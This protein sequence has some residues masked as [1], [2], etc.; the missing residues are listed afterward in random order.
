MIP[1]ARPILGPG[2]TVLALS[3]PRHDILLLDMSRPKAL[4]DLG[5]IV[6]LVLA[7]ELVAQLAALG[8]VR[9]AVG[10]DF[11]PSMFDDP[12]FERITSMVLLPFRA[13]GVLVVVLALVR[14]RG[15]TRR[16]IG[17]ST[18]RW[19]LDALI[20]AGATLA[21]FVLIYMWQ[22]LVWLVWPEMIKQMMEN[23]DR[24]IA[25]IPKLHPLS[26][27][28]VACIVG[29]Y[30]EVLFRGFLLPRLRR[31]TNSWPLAIIISTA[32]FTALHAGDQTF[33]A[34]GP[35]TI[36]SLVFSVVT[37]WRRSIVPAIV[38]HAAFD[39]AQFVGLYIAYGDKWT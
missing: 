28:G 16:A 26:L 13:L 18:P 9:L 34:L 11:D 32:V 6:L 22:F 3:K 24:L 8:A 33:A 7:A 4:A 29:I 14:L 38:G 12:A 19:A 27:C 1:M 35:I 20:G 25:L 37:V 30:E 36:L 39:F 21:A 31:V 23:A 10:A 2:A 5:L 17:A 15:Q